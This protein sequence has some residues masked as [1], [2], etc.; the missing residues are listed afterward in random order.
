MPRVLVTGGLGF[1]GSAFARRLATDG[2]QVRVLDNGLR[3]SGGAEGL[4]V[5][6]EVVRGD[7][8]DPGVVRA[9]VAGC[10][11][12]CHLAAVNG[13]R[14][15]YERP[16]LVLDVG[17]RGI[18]NVLD[19]CVAERVGDLVV[20]SSS[21]VYQSPDVVPTDE[22]VALSIPDALN[23]RY[24]YAGSKIITELLAI[25]Y[26]RE[27]LARVVVCR[28]HNVYGPAMGWDHV[29][30]EL[31]ARLRRLAPAGGPGEVALPV[32]GSGEETRAF[33]YIDDFV[34]GLM[35]LVD[36]GAHLGIYHVG[37]TEEVTI[38]D[39]AGRLA[40]QLGLRARIV[41]GA[42]ASGA[43]T[44]RCPDIARM[45]DLGWTPRVA[46]DQGLARTIAWYVAHEPPE[47]TALEGSD[48]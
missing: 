4:P 25:N 41:P 35:T 2:W 48:R 28:P 33:V 44:R 12:V 5:E 3:V 45:L 42:P 30:P 31:I 38:A 37:T 18:L 6:V 39:L 14:H 13:T 16:V 24:S 11:R 15:F 19:A 46:L 21:E 22:T 36:K 29:I 8:R 10:D 17:V 34:D 32:Q 27:H 26:G 43:T 23:P 9:A 7:V 40:A 20:V 47:A 1:I